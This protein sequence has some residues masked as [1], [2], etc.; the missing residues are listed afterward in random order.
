[1]LF[2]ITAVCSTSRQCGGERTQKQSCS[3]WVPQQTV[4]VAGESVFRPLICISPLVVPGKSAAENM[5]GRAIL[6]LANGN[7]K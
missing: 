6:H 3:A 1:M 5:P 7:R 2:C 4:V